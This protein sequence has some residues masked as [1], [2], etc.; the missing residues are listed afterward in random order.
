MIRHEAHILATQVGGHLATLASPEEQSLYASSGIGWVGLF[1]DAGDGVPGV[2]SDGSDASATLSGIANIQ[3]FGYLEDGSLQ[4]T[5]SLQGDT[6]T[7]LA[8]IEMTRPY[9]IEHGRLEFNPTSGDWSYRPDIN[10]DGDERF[11]VIATDIEGR[12]ALSTIQFQVDDVDDLGLPSGDLRV[13]GIEDYEVHG[14]LYGVDLD[15]PDNTVLVGDTGRI[16]G[17]HIREFNTLPLSAV[18]EG[19][20][21]SEGLLVHYSF[22]DGNLDALTAHAQAP[23]TTSDRF[24][25]REKAIRLE[26]HPISGSSALIPANFHPSPWLCGSVMMET[27]HVKLC[28]PTP[29]VRMDFLLD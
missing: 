15:D 25:R 11:T 14:R 29:M 16:G 17:G 24:G 5:T 6:V 23:S 12:E 1:A 27:T 7:K 8:F 26:G 18:T 28:F 3:Q 2:W 4:H 10:F 20:M 22:N 21:H 13:H 19:T 9:A